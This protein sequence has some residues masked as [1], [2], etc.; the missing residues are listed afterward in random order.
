MHLD[1]EKMKFYKKLVLWIVVISVIFVCALL[2]IICYPQAYYFND[3]I[4]YKNFHVYYDKKIP[5]Q[6]YAT[7]DTVD[8]L[9]R[10]SDFYDPNVQFKIFLRS[11]ADNYNVLPF[12]FPDRGSGCA[13][14]VIKNV[15]LYRSDCATN[16]SYNHVGHMR[17]LSSVLAHELMHVLVENKMFLK[18]KMAYFD[19][20]GSF[21]KEEGYAEYI[22]GDLPIKLDE[23]LKILNNQALPKYAWHFE[24]FKYWLAVRYLILE[25]HMTFEEILDTQLKLDDVL[26]EAKCAEING[27]LVIDQ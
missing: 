26:N 14:S 20:F 27:C 24:Y 23:G 9:I 22:A 16:T 15:F 8:Q 7:L 2:L 13:V 11:D 6:I 10:K 5:D 18:S 12:Q 25:K 21:W 1:Q 3:K 17:T 4:V 19:Q